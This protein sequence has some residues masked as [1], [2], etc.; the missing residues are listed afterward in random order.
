MIR[1]ATAA[2][3]L[4]LSPLILPAMAQTAP[5][6]QTGDT[7]MAKAQHAE[8]TALLSKYV[9]PGADGVNRFDYGALAAS[10]AD[11]AAL[12][13]YIA[14][15]AAMDLSASSKANFANWANL[16]N[17]VTVRY[18]VGKYPLKSIRDGYISGPWKKIKVMAGGREISLNDIEHEVLRKDYDD[19]RVHYAINCASFSCPNLL[20]K[21]WEAATLDAG[22]DKAAAEYVNN[23]RGVTVTPRGLVVSDIYNWFEKDFGGSKQ[24][25]IAHLLQYADPA[26]TAQ[27]KANPKIRKYDYDWSLNDTK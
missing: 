22:L 3:A 14:R 13:A 23:S 12:D 9:K 17:A 15:F 4:A 1:T 19:P 10:K 5:S 21:A 24:A 11:R 8:W 20:T 6:A 26:L 27:I 18:I 2:L 25:V 16:Y 7:Q